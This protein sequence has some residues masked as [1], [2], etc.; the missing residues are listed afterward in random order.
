MYLNT[1]YIRLFYKKLYFVFQIHIL[2][3]CIWNTAHPYLQAATLG[4]HQDQVISIWM[5]KSQKLLVT[6]TF[7]YHVSN[8]QQTLT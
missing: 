3:T 4:I 8:Q 6:L 1:K 5:G 7:T 2:N